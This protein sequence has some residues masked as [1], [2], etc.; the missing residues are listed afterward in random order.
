MDFTGFLL[1]FEWNLEL[2]SSKSKGMGLEE[3][4]VM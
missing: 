3:P 2:K 1:I 4:A